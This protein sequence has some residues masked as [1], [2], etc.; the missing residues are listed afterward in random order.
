MELE[1]QN[2]PISVTLIKPGPIDTP[3]TQHARDYLTDE[4]KHVPPVYAPDAV[5]EAILHAATTP[6][7]A[8]FVGS[9]AVVI[10]AMR[11]I[12]PRLGDKVVEKLL[13][14]GTHSGRPPHDGDILFEGTSGEARE[15]GDYPVWFSQPP[16]T[17]R[18]GCAPCSRVWPRSE[19]QWLYAHISSIGGIS[20]LAHR[21]RT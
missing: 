13:I 3:F 21:D 9:N 5:A 14:S 18:P 12:S 11:Q 17:L 16:S 7:R 2:V 8:L 6:T 1:D 4:P 15:R 19:P 10:S 20:S